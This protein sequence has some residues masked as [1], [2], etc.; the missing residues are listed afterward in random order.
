VD[1]LFAADAAANK[2]RLIQAFLQEIIKFLNQNSTTDEITS[3]YN[4]E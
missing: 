1:W 2:A 4:F 3:K